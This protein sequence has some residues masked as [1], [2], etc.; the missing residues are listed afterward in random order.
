MVANVE[1]E[2]TNGDGPRSRA[3]LSIGQAQKFT[4]A[5]FFLSRLLV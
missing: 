1:E 5:M 2:H 3:E 4:E